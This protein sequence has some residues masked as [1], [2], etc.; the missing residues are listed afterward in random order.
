MNNLSV[1][2]DLSKVNFFLKNHIIQ[3]TFHDSKCLNLKKI[4]FFYSESIYFLEYIRSLDSK[5]DANHILGELQKLHKEKLFKKYKFKSFTLIHL[6]NDQCI[7]EDNSTIMLFTG[8]V[9]NINEIQKLIYES[10]D[11]AIDEID[12]MSVA[13]II[14]NLYLIFEKKFSNYINGLFHI[15]LFNKVNEKLKIVNDRF[16]ICFVYYYDN[17]KRYISSSSL[18]ILMATG[19]KRK[20]SLEA[21]DDYLSYRISQ[22]LIQCIKEYISFRRQGFIE[23]S[24]ELE[25][26]SYLDL[27]SSL[28]FNNKKE[29]IDL[30]KEHFKN[31]TL[32]SFNMPN[33]CFT[34]SGG[35]DSSIIS[36]LASEHTSIN[37]FN[38]SVGRNNYIDEHVSREISS[39]LSTNHSVVKLAATDLLDQEFFDMCINMIEEPTVNSFPNEIKLNKTINNSFSTTVYGSM[40]PAAYFEGYF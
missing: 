14:F 33:P 35:V 21:L 28:S 9:K 10:T 15:I 38:L 32:G 16:G 12:A 22:P 27:K 23:V 11:I 40:A 24:S 5:S 18:D 39:N 31:S 29:T 20:L 19:L 1:L 25:I 4:I 3:T 36:K 37:T 8:M 17:I 2:F 34:L 26:Y 7:F 6:D 30:F 13:E